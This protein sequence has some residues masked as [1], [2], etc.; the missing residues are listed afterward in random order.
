MHVMDSLADIDPDFF[1]DFRVLWAENRPTSLSDCDEIH[2][3]PKKP[4]GF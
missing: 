1:H 2:V 4:T 3:A